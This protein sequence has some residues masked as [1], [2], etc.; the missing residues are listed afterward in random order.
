LR[1]AFRALA[2]QSSDLLW[3]AVCI[4]LRASYRIGEV[5]SDAGATNT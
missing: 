5:T 4:G 2:R 1:S 3:Q